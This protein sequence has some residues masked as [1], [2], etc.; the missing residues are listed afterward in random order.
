[1]TTINAG[2]RFG[3]SLRSRILQLFIVTIAVVAALTLF[4]AR[5]AA[6]QHST[7]QLG[8]HQVAASRVV[9]DRLDTRSKLLH[10]GLRDISRSF[11][12]KE[13]VASGREDP[14][15]LAA[16]MEN[17]RSRL[18]ADFFV[19]L[20]EKAATIVSSLELNLNGIDP[21]SYAAEGLTWFDLDGDHFLLKAAPLRFA[22]RSRR[23]NAWLLMGHRSASLIN[24]DLVAFTGMQISLATLGG[25]SAIWGSTLSPAESALLEARLAGLGTGVGEAYIGDNRVITGVYPL[26]GDSDLYTITTLP[27]SEAYLNYQT[28][29]IN[30]GIV[31]LVAVA[32]AFLAAMRISGQI[33][34]P[35]S[36]LVAAAKRIS[37]GLDAAELPEQGTR[38]VLVLSKAVRDMQDGIR[39]REREINRLAYHDSLCAIPNRNGF[40]SHLTSLLEA[41]GDNE[42]ISVALLDVDRFKEINDTVGHDTGDR[43]LVLI[44]ERLRSHTREDD[45]VARLG[46]DEF[47]VVYRNGRSLELG[48]SLARAFEVPFSIDGLVLDVDASMGIVRAPEHATDAIGLLQLADI[49]LYACKASHDDFVIY[50][51][52]LNRHSVKRLKLMAELKEALNSGQLK[53]HFQPKLTLASAA[54]DCVECLLRWEHPQ[55]GFVPPDEFIELAEQTGA[56]RQVTRW[57]LQT[58]LEQQAQW[59]AQGVSVAMAVNISAVDL[60]DMSLPAFVGELQSRFALSPGDLTLEITESA[61]MKDP[62]SAL[63]ALK[64]LDRMGVVL[65]IDD[66]GTG[67]SSMAQLKQ[68]PVKELKI[69]KTFVLAMASN[70]DDQI[71]VRTLISLA[72]NLGLETVAEGLEDAAAERMLQSMGCTRAQGYHVSKPLPAKEFLPWLRQRQAKLRIAA[73]A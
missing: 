11:S 42:Q 65:S 41:R 22:E 26:A 15:S 63:L 43:L 57:V 66:F 8:V 14:Q 35:I 6:Y 36:M 60:T 31:L 73:S 23:V 52:A 59:R 51:Q 30:L 1:M 19:V 71:M 69:D 50:S 3:N 55:Y 25:A 4:L 2:P 48:E 53:L 33:T 39:D 49:A 12:V 29:L 9:A 62:E 72:E 45:F 7:E 17:Y 28:L 40:V 46:G 58:A 64:T 32:L 61:V 38:E 24:D 44:A 20:D 34:Q 56:I 13:L 16:A 21:A 5:E 67:F 70:R 27:H 10:S 54:V 37:L 47:A 68:M 18:G